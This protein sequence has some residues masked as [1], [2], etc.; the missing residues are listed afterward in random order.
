MKLHRTLTFFAALA[1]GSLAAQAGPAQSNAQQYFVTSDITS[2]STSTSTL[3]RAEVMAARKAG[4]M[5]GNDDWL[6]TPAPQAVVGHPRTREEVRAEA[7]EA[8]HSGFSV[9]NG[10][11]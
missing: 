8:A 10:E 9:I 6:Q 7:I 1:L 4:T 2:T 11:D 5:P 3:T